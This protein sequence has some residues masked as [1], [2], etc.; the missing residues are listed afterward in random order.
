MA[1]KVYI[2]YHFGHNVVSI[3]CFCSMSPTEIVP[4]KARTALP[5]TT[6]HSITE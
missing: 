4:N 6:T 1:K 2:V 5:F 3:A